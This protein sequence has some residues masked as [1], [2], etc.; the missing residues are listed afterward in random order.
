MDKWAKIT[1]E[2]IVKIVDSM[3]DRIQATI[4]ANSGHTR[5]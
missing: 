3:P 2:E 5:W 4:S 1:M